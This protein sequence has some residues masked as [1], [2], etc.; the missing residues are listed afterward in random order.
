MTVLN[1]EDGQT[2]RGSYLSARPS[3]VFQSP[4]VGLFISFKRFNVVL[5]LACL[6]F[7]PYSELL[8][9]PSSY[10]LPQHS[11]DEMGVEQTGSGRG[12]PPMNPGLATP[13]FAL[14]GLV[15]ILFVSRIAILTHH[16]RRLHG[17][18]QNDSQ[19]RHNGISSFY[20]SLK[21]HVLY[22]PLFSTR[23][24]REF[25]LWGRMHMGTVPLRLESAILAVY[26][27]LNTIFLFV[28]IDW[29]A[30]YGEKMF[31]LKY[32]AGH[33]AVMNTPALVITAGRNN[34]LI[35]LLGIPF[36]TFNLVHRWVGRLIAIN[37]VI[38][39]G[40]VLGRIEHDSEW[41]GLLQS[42]NTRG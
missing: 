35:P 4:G 25:R 37:S 20:A 14:A 28:L 3:S 5:L 24:N 32:A 33:L 22:A 38:H 30:A 39:M 31:Q 10:H 9:S 7:G 13:L 12:E 17:I 36:D 34:P 41:D 15:V 29:K 21:K 26:L 23:H 40:C 27:T 16:R 18:L 6:V 19:R 2:F 42:K 1:M 11:L 8:Y